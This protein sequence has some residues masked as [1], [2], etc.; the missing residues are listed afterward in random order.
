MNTLT[1]KTGRL[2]LVGACLLVLAACSSTPDAP[3]DKEDERASGQTSA[4]VDQRWNFLLLGTRERLDFDERPYFRIGDDGRVSGVE[5]LSDG[6]PV[7]YEAPIV[8]D[9][10]G[11]L[12]I[13]QDLADLSDG[14]FDTNV[15]YSQFSSA[16]REIVTV[17]EPVEWR[18]ALVLKPT[19]RSAGYLWYFP[20]T[21]TE[22][23]VGVGFQMNE[24]PMKL[25]RALREDMRSREELQGATVEDKLGGALPTRRPY[26]SAVAD[27]FMAAGDAAAHVNPTTGGGI[28]G[29]AYAGQYAGEQAIEAL[30][31]GNVYEEA[32]WHYNERVMDHFG[33]RYA[34]LD[35][36]NIFTTAYDVDELTGLLA[37]LPMHSISEALYSGSA[38]LG[39]GL[40]IKTLL[41]SF[42][43]W[44]TIYDL[45]RAKHRADELLDHYESYPDSPDGLPAWQDRRD[46][47]LETVYETTGADK[48]Y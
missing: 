20:R 32:L 15:A 10:G 34:A 14:T 12:S 22:I 8:I 16:Y 33:S 2:A 3:A 30:E 5:A 4:V 41:K 36:Y 19:E 7:T 48:K 18:D 46:E 47:L 39:W 37:R 35:V 40:K 31:D 29:A 26:D 11:P 9:A 42:G 43:H 1:F 21:P 45:Y 23:N 6:K 44:Q 38:D 27:G 13:V 17:E 28:A 25:L 24:Q